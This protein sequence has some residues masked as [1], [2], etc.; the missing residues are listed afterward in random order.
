MILIPN[1]KNFYT[2]I[3]TFSFGILPMSQKNISVSILKFSDTIVM[4]K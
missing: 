1:E 2:V 4:L 3:H